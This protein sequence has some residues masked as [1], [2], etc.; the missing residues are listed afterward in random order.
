MDKG[1]VAGTEVGDA[2]VVMDET[3]KL[4]FGVGD[5]E[6]RNKGELVVVVSLVVLVVAAG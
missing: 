4:C 1:R 5:G 3:E 6:L 2:G